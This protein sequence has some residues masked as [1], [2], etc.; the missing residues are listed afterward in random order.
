M[1]ALPTLEHPEPLI[2]CETSSIS[3]SFRVNE[4][5]FLTI[6]RVVSILNNVIPQEYFQMWTFCF[7]LSMH[8]SLQIIHLLKVLNIIFVQLLLL[9]LHYVIL[10]SIL[11]LTK[12]LFSGYS[13]CWTDSLCL[14]SFLIS[15]PLH[16]FFL[17]FVLQKFILNLCQPLF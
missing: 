16:H 9:S 4:S 10:F 7:T 14:L 2:K 5:F 11:F 3:I 1:A 17:F 15:P 12:Y 6:L 8:I 13:L